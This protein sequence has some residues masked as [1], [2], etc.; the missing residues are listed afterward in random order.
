MVLAGVDVL[1]TGDGIEVAVPSSKR[2][3][4]GDILDLAKRIQC[5]PT[6]GGEGV[7]AIEMQREQTLQGTAGISHGV[8]QAAH[9]STPT[10]LR[11]KP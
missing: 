2:A 11:T 7:A 6:I 10:N 8:E 5:I 3:G 9:R 1:I 4:G